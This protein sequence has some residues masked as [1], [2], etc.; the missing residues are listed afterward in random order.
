MADI[1]YLYGHPNQQ[2]LVREP[3]DIKPPEDDEEWTK[4]FEPQVWPSLSFPSHPLL[5]PPPSQPHSHTLSFLYF[6]ADAPTDPDLLTPEQLALVVDGPA[7]VHIFGHKDLEALFLQLASIV[8][9]LI[10]CRVSP[11]QKRM[12]VR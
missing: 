12:I 9:A 2:P 6:Q 7:L 3:S 5:P 10:A 1:A 11:A 8:G 4:C